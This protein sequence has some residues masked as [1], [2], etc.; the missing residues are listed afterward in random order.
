MNILVCVTKKETAKELIE[1]GMKLKSSHEGELFILHV[2]KKEIHHLSREIEYFYS[3]CKSYDAEF[4]VIHSDN[5]IKSIIKHVKEKDIDKI[6]LGVTR[7]PNPKDSTLF[8]LQT[9]LH[10]MAETIIV[11]IRETYELRDVI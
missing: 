10:G 7:Q 6:I 9:A 8:R 5:V 4:G 3:L 1:R 2:T 11:P